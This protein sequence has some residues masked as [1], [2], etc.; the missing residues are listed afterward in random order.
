MRN[1]KL[2]SIVVFVLILLSGVHPIKAQEKADT[3]YSF[4]FVPGK[5][6]FYVPW[7]GNDK[8]LARL[9]NCVTRYRKE[10]R[11]GKIPLRVDGYCNS[12][13]GRKENLN[14]AYIRANR[15][16]S[17]LITRQRLTEECFITRNH[18]T[19]GDFVTV[20]LKVP[21]TSAPQPTA[22][23]ATD[24]AS[25]ESIINKVETHETEDVDNSYQET[26]TP[27]AQVAKS[28]AADRYAL[29][30]R[31]NLL[32]WATLTPDLG[33]EWRVHPSWSILVNGS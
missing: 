31:A 3:V 20:S 11:D 27:M 8:E 13:Q 28:A 7:K 32:R 30:L 17:E 14:V 19:E 6:M 21:K 9:E 29:S 12:L 33:I 22:S 26:Q 10:I 1:K 15:V 16:K 18:A 23:T 2:K 25:T 24:T 5:N 4:R